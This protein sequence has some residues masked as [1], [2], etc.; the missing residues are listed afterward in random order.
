MDERQAFGRL[1]DEGRQRAL[2]MA[3]QRIHDALRTVAVLRKY[4]GRRCAQLAR[5]L[6][7]HQSPIAETSQQ[8]WSFRLNC[9]QRLYMSSRDF[10]N[11]GWNAQPVKFIRLQGIKWLFGSQAARQCKAIECAPHIITVQVEERSLP[12]FPHLDSDNSSP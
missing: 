5:H 10:L 6:V 8:V 1:D 12:R 9:A 7:G 3:R 4:I 2:D 11:G